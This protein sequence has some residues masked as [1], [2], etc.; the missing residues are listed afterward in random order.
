[1]IAATQLG[2]KLFEQGNK[3]TNNHMSRRYHTADL[4]FG[5]RSLVPVYLTSLSAS[6]LMLWSRLF[7]R[8]LE[9]PRHCFGGR[10]DGRRHAQDILARGRG[11]LHLG[12]TRHPLWVIEQITRHKHT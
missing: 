3:L 1:M 6:R 10:L 9:T 12:I 2:G 7:H 4:P 11:I 8:H 5:A